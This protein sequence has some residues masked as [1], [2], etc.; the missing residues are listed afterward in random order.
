MF[1]IELARFIAD[2]GIGIAEELLVTGPRVCARDQKVLCE[3]AAWE[4][5]QQETH[6]AGSADRKHARLLGHS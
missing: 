5:A 6:L 1:D 4:A 3:G 2:D